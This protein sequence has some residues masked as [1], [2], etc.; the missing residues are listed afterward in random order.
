MK[1]MITTLVLVL[2]MAAN[3]VII[4]FDDLDASDSENRFYIPQGYEEFSWLGERGEESWINNASFDLSLPALSGD[5]YAWSNG[6][7]RLSLSDGL[8]NVESLWINAIFGAGNPDP[9]VTFE[10]YRDGILIY[11][12]DLQVTQRNWTFASLN[13]TGI[14]FFTFDG[15]PNTNIAVDDISYSRAVPEPSTLALLGIGLAGIGFARRRKQA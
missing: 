3:A 8:F 15:F 11:S 2:P 12:S 10:G 9:L 6:G 13:F 4:D 14:D 7:A 5:N 1:R